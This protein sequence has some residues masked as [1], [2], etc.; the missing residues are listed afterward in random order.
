MGSEMCIRDRQEEEQD[1]E[2]EQEHCTAASSTWQAFFCPRVQRW[3]FW[4]SEFWG[5]HLGE[6]GG[7]LRR[8]LGKAGRARAVGC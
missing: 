6:A 1:Q 8:A 4:D 7:A 5:H 2:Q 3:W